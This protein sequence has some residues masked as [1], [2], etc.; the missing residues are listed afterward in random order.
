MEERHV[1]IAPEGE[2]EEIRQI[3]QAKGFEGEALDSAVDVITGQRERWIDTMMTEEHGLPPISRSPGKAALMTFLAFLLCGS[4]PLLP[5]VV[6]RSRLDLGLDRHD[7]RHLLLHRFAAQPLVADPLVAG[8]NWR[9]SAIGITAAA[10]AYLVGLIARPA[11][12]DSGLGPTAG[13]ALC[14]TL[15]AMAIKEPSFTIGIEEEYLLVDKDSRDL[16]PE[17]PPA[18]L[19]KCE[20]A[21]AR[22]GQPGVPALADRGRHPR[23]QV[24]AG[25]ARPDR[26][27]PR[28][29]RP[30]RR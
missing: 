29:R 6:R 24:D 22:P 15:R 16:A 30:H 2:R 25:G 23:V 21:L 13:L 26:P 11:S 14:A 8:R 7:R 18:L 9:R 28:H 12:S 5:F 19:A 1:D 17:P 27:P 20:E 4:V 3:F 10:M